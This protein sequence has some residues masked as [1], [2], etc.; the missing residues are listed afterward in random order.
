MLSL[1]VDYVEY[2]PAKKTHRLTDRPIRMTP[3]PTTRSTVRP[4]PSASAPVRFPILRASKSGSGP[5]T[6]SIPLDIELE[7][8]ISLPSAVTLPPPS[9]PFAMKHP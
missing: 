2:R 1:S 3:K 7:L 4:Q 9:Q 5:P 6:N 8:E